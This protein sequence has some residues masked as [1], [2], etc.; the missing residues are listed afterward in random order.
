[1]LVKIYLVNMKTLKHK[2]ACILLGIKKSD[3][4]KTIIHT[5]AKLGN[6]IKMTISLNTFKYLDKVFI[7]MY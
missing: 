3:F 5:L 1:M 4:F 2:H 7:F 6:A